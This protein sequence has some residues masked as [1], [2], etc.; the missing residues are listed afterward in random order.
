MNYV[1]LEHIKHMGQGSRHTVVLFGLRVTLY[2][3]SL[4][5]MS[6]ANLPFTSENSVFWFGCAMP[7]EIMFGS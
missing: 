3:N 4:P 2:W 1:N 6:S 5:W 7:D